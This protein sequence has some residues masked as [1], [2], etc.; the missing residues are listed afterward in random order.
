MTPGGT[1]ASCAIPTIQAARTG[2]SELG[3]RTT[4]FPATTAA[5]VIPVRIASGKFHGVTTAPT[6]SGM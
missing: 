5:I 1:P 6:P 3:L 2:V 4:V